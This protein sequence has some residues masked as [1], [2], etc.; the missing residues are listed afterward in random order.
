MMNRTCI[1]GHIPLGMFTESIPNNSAEPDIEVVRPSRRELLHAAI[2]GNYL[3]LAG[4]GLLQLAGRILH[5]DMWHS[6]RETS[7]DALCRQPQVYWPEYV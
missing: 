6:P 4:L 2:A 5:V 3:P 7:K 1:R